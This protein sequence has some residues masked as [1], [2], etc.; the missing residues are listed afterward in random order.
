MAASSTAVGSQS[1]SDDL[2]SVHGPM[3]DEC[4]ETTRLERTIQISSGWLRSSTDSVV[5]TNPLDFGGSRFINLAHF[6][7]CVSVLIADCAYASEGEL[8]FPT[9]SIILCIRMNI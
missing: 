5:E 1:P 7:L 8:G 4:R 2:G 3:A 6:V 9:S